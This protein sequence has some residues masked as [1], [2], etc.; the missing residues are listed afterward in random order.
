MSLVEYPKIIPYIKFEHF[1]I[2][3]FR[4]MQHIT[5]DKQTDKQTDS[6]MLAMPTDIV[7]VG[8]KRNDKE[9]PLLSFVHF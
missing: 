1:G 2:I 6:K 5:P 3:R 7:C 9:T 4:V 8:N